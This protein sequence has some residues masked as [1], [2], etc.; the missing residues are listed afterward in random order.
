MSVFRWF[1]AA[2]AVLVCAAPAGA[3]QVPPVPALTVAVV[4]ADPA[5]APSN[6]PAALRAVA[7]VSERLERLGYPVVPLETLWQVGPRQVQSAAEVAS[8]MPAGEV[9]TVVGLSLYISVDVQGEAMVGRLRIASDL[10]KV[11]GGGS[12]GAPEV[13]A[14]DPGI[15]FP[16]GCGQACMFEAIGDEAAMLGTELAVMIA[17]RLSLR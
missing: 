8:R 13:S 15:P 4:D 9:Q 5:T 3:Q 12:V 1:A 6:A 17:A 10:R 14:P 11:P 2:L 16:E 7:A